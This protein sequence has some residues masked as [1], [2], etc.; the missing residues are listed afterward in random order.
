M[1]SPREALRSPGVP[2]LLASQVP[3]DFADWLDYVAVA[4]LLAFVWEAPT[5]AFA[6]FAVCLGAPYLL[7][8][9]LAGALV[10]RLPVRAVLIGSNLGRA[11][12]TASLALAPDWPVLVSLVFLRGSVDA[13]YTPAKQA[14][15]QALVPEER[16]MAVNAA[17]HGVNQTSKIAA[18][19]LGGA[20]LLVLE[21]AEVF[22]ANAALSLLA[23]GM[24]ARLVPVPRPDGP[25]A[26]VA[27]GIAEG[28]RTV[29]GIPPLRRAL[30]LMAGGFFAMF[31]YDT[32]IAPL[33]RDL[34]FSQATLGL[35]LACVGAGGVAASAV[36]TVREG[37]P[38]FLVGASALLSAACI[39]T[40]G[41]AEITG[42]WLPRAAF[43]GLFACIGAASA[44]TVVP[45]RTVIQRET[46][47]DR[48]A[49]VAALS[50]A[51]NT[52]ALL[53]APF[54]GA[55]LA[56]ATSVGAAFLAGACV[57]L[58]MAILALR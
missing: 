8:G 2:T 49:R 11:A 14:V 45:I 50:E 9:P 15:I 13:F 57:L 24:L 20:A 51:A 54:L 3:A 5:I 35:A 25:S 47:P 33:T 37:P 53:S 52:V 56:A 26:G 19:A 44:A 39:G 58:F 12:A 27:A 38:F 36:L 46:P 22:L 6:A 48:I 29:L 34:G 32:L 41:A 17:S 30:G 7:V 18:P 10:D 4:T 40:L 16:R 42:P 55:A 23:A 31:L 21:P 1:T 28:L 43:L